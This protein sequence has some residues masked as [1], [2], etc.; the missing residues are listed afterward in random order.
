MKKKTIRIESE[1]SNDNIKWYEGLFKKA[2]N[3]QIDYNFVDYEYVE[4]DEVINDI[5]SFDSNT[6]IYLKKMISDIMNFN[7][8]S[9]NIIKI[10]FENLDENNEKFKLNYVK[11]F[12][13]SSIY[14]I[15]PP[16]ININVGEYVDIIKSKFSDETTGES[17]EILKL[18]S[19]A[20]MKKIYNE[21]MEKVD[22]ELQLFMFELDKSYI[23]IVKYILEIMNNRIES[24]KNESYHLERKLK[25]YKKII[26]IIEGNIMEP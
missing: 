21:I 13:E 15:K 4:I 19:K 25:Y 18:H 1:E 20:I 16:S 7:I 6:D 11:K 3:E 14:S 10:I 5:N 22:S 23:S 2:N 24:L 9:E 17:I 8:L 12:V 26:S